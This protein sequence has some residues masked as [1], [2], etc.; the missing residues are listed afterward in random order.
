M[1]SYRY[2][3]YN[4][5]HYI[6]KCNI[7]CRYIKCNIQVYTYEAIAT[8][9][10]MNRSITNKSFLMRLCNHSLLPFPE[11]LSPGTTD[12]LSVTVD[13]LEESWEVTASKYGISFWGDENV[14]ELNS[15]DV[16]TAL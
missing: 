10:K 15:S 11:H 7:W 6:I 8:T 3:K 13:Q 4:I 1:I 14:L 16:C 2:L 9:K 12:L 5:Q